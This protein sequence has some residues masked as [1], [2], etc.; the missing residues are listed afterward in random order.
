MLGLTSDEAAQVA[1]SEGELLSGI[2][3]V[4]LQHADRR[5]EQ[6]RGGRWTG[7]GMLLKIHCGAE[8][9]PWP[10]KELGKAN[11]TVWQKALRT[12]LQ[13]A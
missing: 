3:Q 4:Q 2:S 10:G 8:G 5:W 7:H 9:E 11:H 1:T 13:L 12:L 6:M